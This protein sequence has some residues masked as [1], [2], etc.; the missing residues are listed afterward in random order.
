M[1][2]HDNPAHLGMRTK[3]TSS[4]TFTDAITREDTK[5]CGWELYDMKNDPHETRN[6]YHD[7]ACKLAQSLK[8]YWQGAQTGRR[9]GSHYPECE[10]IVREFG[11]T[12]SGQSQGPQN[13][14]SIWPGA[15]ESLRPK[16][17]ASDTRET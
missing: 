10:K 2:H 9:P 5:P 8:S 11:T 17:A 14:A 13:S 3:A 15:K 4:F 1:A 12:T 6:L 16:F 7:P